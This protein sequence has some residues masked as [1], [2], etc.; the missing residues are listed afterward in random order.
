MIGVTELR[1]GAVFEDAQGVWEVIEYK[2]VKMGRGSATI[3][4]KVRNLKGG[5]I[6][7]KTF[8]SGQRVENVSL[9]KR[10][11]QYLYVKGNELVFMDPESYEQ[12]SF[13]RSVLGGRENYLQENE[14][15]D[16]KMVDNQVLDVEIPR[17][18]TVK[19]KETGPGVKGNSVSNVFKDAVLDNGIKIKVPLFINVGDKIKV[20]TRTNIYVERVK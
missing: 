19:I 18:V 13:D 7:E 1:A 10:K 5:S 15:Y 9:S 4:V 3:R 6:I 16:L 20:D 14:N 12:F 11:G 8:T 2:H 17:L